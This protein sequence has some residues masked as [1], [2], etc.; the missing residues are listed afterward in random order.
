MSCV[1]RWELVCSFHARTWK[2]ETESGHG[3]HKLECCMAFGTGIS[4][5]NIKRILKRAEVTL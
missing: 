5:G 2:Q 3:Q 1:W 4:V